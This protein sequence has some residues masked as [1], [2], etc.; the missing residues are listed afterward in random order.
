MATKQKTVIGELIPPAIEIDGIDYPVERLPLR[1][2]FKFVGLIQ[3]FFGDIV[4]MVQGNFPPEVIAQIRENSEDQE[5][6]NAI[7]AA[8]LSSVDSSVNGILKKMLL[9]ED[10]AYE[11]VAL[12][13]NPRL[14]GDTAFGLSCPT[15][16]Q[17][18][19]VAD[20]IHLPDAVKIVVTVIKAELTE[21]FFGEIMEGMRIV[22]QAQVF[23]MDTSEEDSDPTTINGSGKSS[24][25]LEVV[26]SDMP[27]PALS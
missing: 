5:R 8:H 10:R 27:T 24:P 19:W 12:C 3:D 26:G 4:D 1:K 2:I 6:I 16:V 17:I 25:N 18:E 13:L 20:H 23:G 22:K 15:P 7:I 14:Q 11:L 9:K 21:D